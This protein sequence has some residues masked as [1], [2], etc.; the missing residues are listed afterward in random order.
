MLAT[1][2][3][4]NTMDSEN[5]NI[6]LSAESAAGLV[7][8]DILPS[9]FIGG[10][11]DTRADV[12]VVGPE[13]GGLWL[14]PAGSTLRIPIEETGPTHDFTNGGFGAIRVRST[15]GN[16][17]MAFASVA[18]P[19][20]AAPV[21]GAAFKGARFRFPLV[22]NT[23]PQTQTLSICATTLGNAQIQIRDLAT[24]TDLMALT[25]VPGLHTLFFTH[26]THSATQIEVVFAGPDGV[27]SGL[28]QT[29]S[30]LRLNPAEH[31]A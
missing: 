29:P 30:R 17:F 1:E 26:M 18:G 2:V 13:P 23:G 4:F 24:G 10:V 20:T 31:R 9:Q 6:I 14:I 22:G 12:P 11:L 8:V 5:I 25:D 16:D 7:Q 3:V 15:D 27:V 28:L 21:S 19:R